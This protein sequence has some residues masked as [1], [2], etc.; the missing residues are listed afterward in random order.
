LER[1][2]GAVSTL[3]AGC[4]V[5]LRVV[6]RVVTVVVVPAASGP[7]VALVARTER[8][9]RGAVPRDV[10]AL[11]RRGGVAVVGDEMRVIRPG[12]PR[13]PKETGGDEGGDERARSGHQL[14]SRS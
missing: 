9:C 13:G 2:A 14:P 8:D 10:R 7:L 5:L 12:S 4:G 1:E 11:R 3:A 6:G